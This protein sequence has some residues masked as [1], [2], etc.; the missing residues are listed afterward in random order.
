MNP[1]FLGIDHL[2]IAVTD[3]K[4]A[5]ETYGQVLGLHLGKVEELP[6]RGLRVQFVNTGGSRLELLAPT[7]DD[8][9]ISAFLS[10]RGE[11]IHHVCLRVKNIDT[12][13]QQMKKNGARLI[14]ETPK[15]GAGGHRVAF[16]HPKGAHGVLLELV[17][18]SSEADHD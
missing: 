13:L 14:D 11:G 4:A 2:G 12:T 5:S 8:S 9:E 6:D 1:E 15:I 17:E 10:K 16:V 7:R 18:I 3:L